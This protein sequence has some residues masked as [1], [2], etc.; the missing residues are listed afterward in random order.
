MAARCAGCQPPAPSGLKLNSLVLNLNPKLF[1]NL[2]GPRLRLRKSFGWRE[3]PTQPGRAW[4]HRYAGCYFPPEPVNTLGIIIF[5]KLKV[6]PS[7]WLVVGLLLSLAATT[8]VAGAQSNVTLRVL[9]ANT[10]SGSLQSYEAEGIRIFQG[11]KPD[12]VA[13]QEFQYNGSVASNDLRTLVNTAFGSNFYFYCEPNN[14]IPNGI[15][16]RYPI[17]VAGS[18]VDSDPG[19]NDRG[20]VWGRIDIPGTNDLYVVSVHLKASSG[21]DNVARR[22]AEAAELK[23]LISTNFPPNAWFV[24]GGDMNI[25]DPSE[26]AVSTFATFTSDSPVPTDQN[27]DS[28]TNAARAERYDRLLMSFSLTNRLT[29]LVISNVTHADGLVFD[30]RVYSALTNVPPVLS[31]DSGVSGMQHMAVMRA[32]VIPVTDANGTA[33]TI[34]NQPQNLSVAQGS[35]ATFGVV[36]GGPAP[37]TY[38]WRFN[39]ADI[40]G[41]TS[42]TYIRS[43]VQPAHVGSYSVIVSNSAGFTT[44]SNVALLLIVPPPALTTSVAGVLQWQG[45]S[46]LTYTIQTCTNLTQTNWA[47]LGTATSTD[48][49]L[50]FTNTPAIDTQ[51]YYRVV[52]P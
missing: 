36:A 29:P 6:I 38:Q 19:V 44:S 51:R 50:L 35:N 41:A 37:L 48:G 13:I 21:S 1:L 10:T 31:G 43:N 3:K 11:L 20:F 23:A 9:A 5:A 15:I 39:L 26:G 14:G 45:L 18:W 12:I 34:T 2:P 30:S 7:R 40:N 24:V 8:T 25:Y 52:Y 46:N 27:G 49:T 28:D 4:P 16:S 33:P 42:A 47:P 17:I 32:F 22:A